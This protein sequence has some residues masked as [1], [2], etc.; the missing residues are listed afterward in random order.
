MVLQCHTA[1][2]IWL[3]DNITKPIQSEREASRSITI[4][5]LNGQTFLSSFTE[6]SPPKMITKNGWTFCAAESFNHCLFL[7][8]HCKQ[9]HVLQNS[10]EI[11]SQI[12]CILQFFTFWW[13]A[14][15]CYR[16]MRMP[17]SSHI[18]SCGEM[19]FPM[20]AD[21]WTSVQKYPCL[22]CLSYLQS[23][24]KPLGQPS[25]VF[26]IDKAWDPSLQALMILAGRNQSVQNIYLKMK[27]NCP[28]SVN[29]HKKI[30]KCNAQDK[31]LFSPRNK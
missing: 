6:S 9:K 7:L 23:I 1:N 19:I 29:G 18:H 5:T 21:C 4:L 24:A 15:H 13:R 25:V 28:E 16:F 31:H 10:S 2:Q 12:S 26:T 17:H 3:S 30:H 8:A 20:P 14:K 22:D 11:L 27:G